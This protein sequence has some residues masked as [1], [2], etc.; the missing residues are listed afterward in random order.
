MSGDTR[1]GWSG[2]TLEE[3]PGSPSIVKTARG[4]EVTEIYH[5]DYASAEA[6]ITARGLDFGDACPIA[7]GVYSTALLETI[8]INKVGPRQGQVIYIYKVPDPSSPDLPVGTVILEADSNTIDIPIGQHPSA[9]SHFPPVYDQEKQTGVGDWEGIEAYLSPQPI[10]TRTEIISSFTFSE[11][12]II[13][14]VACRMTGA[15][16]ALE[17]MTGATDDKWLQ[18][19]LSIK[20]QGDSYEKTKRFQYDSAG[21]ND[22]I[23]AVATS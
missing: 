21:W 4:A 16:M 10:F 9:L 3:V 6:A 18:V 5:C 19:Q 23:Y 11:A 2:A 12:N 22:E 17:G 20:A 14:N 1:I 8:Q 13:K 15:L 7:G